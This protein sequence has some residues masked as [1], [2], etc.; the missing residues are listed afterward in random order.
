V[1]VLLVDSTWP[2]MLYAGDIVEWLIASTSVYSRH[3]VWLRRIGDIIVIMIITN[4]TS[5]NLLAFRHPRALLWH[6]L[7]NLEQDI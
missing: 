6:R 7:S 3:N 5:T 4:P 2:A 1:Y